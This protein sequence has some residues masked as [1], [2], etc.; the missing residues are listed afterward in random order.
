MIT[1]IVV[2]LGI[3]SVYYVTVPKVQYDVDVVHSILS[4]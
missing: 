3:V 2:I 1:A 4:L